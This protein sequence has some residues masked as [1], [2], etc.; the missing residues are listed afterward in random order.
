LRP[1]DQHPCAVARN[2]RPERNALLGKIEIE[3]VDAHRV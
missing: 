1:N 3:E 2:S